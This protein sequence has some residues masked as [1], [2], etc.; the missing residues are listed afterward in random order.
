MRDFD[1]QYPTAKAQMRLDVAH[2]L[3]RENADMNLTEQIKA[4]VFSHGSMV[5]IAIIGV[6]AL[7][8]AVK[9]AHVIM[10]M[11]FA[12]LGLAAIGTAVWWFF[13]RQ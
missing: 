6:M 3:V 8:L 4:F 13:L 10:R 1:C 7:I 5:V 11:M 9:I 12:L 2:E